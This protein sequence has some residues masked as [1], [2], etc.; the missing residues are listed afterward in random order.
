MTVTPLRKA[1]PTAAIRAKRYR[2]RRQHAVTLHHAVDRVTA[3]VTLA[4]ALGLATVSGSFAVTGLTAIFHGAVVPVIAM[5][6][7]FEL[8]KLAAVAWLGSRTA[9][10]IALKVA[11]AALVVALMLLNALGAYGFL[12]RAHLDHVVA[13]EVAIGVNAADVNARAQ[14]QAAVVADLDKRIEQVDAAVNEAVRRGRANGAMALVE[15]QR[16]NR[17]ELVSARLG[18]ANKLAAM[19]IEGAAVQGERTR[20]A[21]DSGPVRYLAALIGTDDTAIMRWFILLVAGLLDPLAVLL[22]LAAVTSRG[23]L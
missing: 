19:Q 7:A 3:A 14:V 21:A 23:G 8:G 13:G 20:I 2:T 16:R 4:A 15:Q 18:A 17:T 11:I 22:L 1:D 5:G 12:A 9:A 6:A 10:P